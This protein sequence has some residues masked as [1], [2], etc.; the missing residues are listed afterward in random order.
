MSGSAK[1][2]YGARAGAADIDLANWLLLK[3][4]GPLADPADVFEAGERVCQKLSLRLSRRVSMDGAQAILSRALHL[5]RAESPFLKDVRAGRVPEV[6]LEGV[7]LEDVDVR[8]VRQGVL[9]IV[10]ILL[11]LLV[12]LIGEELTLRMVREVW[13]DLPLRQPTQAGNSDGQEAAS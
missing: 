1:N 2:S 5:A 8:E 4:I 13:P 10:R 6:C 9:A 7:N 12:G 11:D 3:E